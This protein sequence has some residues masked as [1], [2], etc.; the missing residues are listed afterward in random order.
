MDTA[1]KRLYPQVS[2]PKMKL[3]MQVFNYKYHLW[4]EQFTKCNL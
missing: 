4:H 3:K 2:F 1:T